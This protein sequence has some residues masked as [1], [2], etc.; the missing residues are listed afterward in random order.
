MTN[1]IDKVFRLLQMHERLSRGESIIKGNAI[2]EFGIPPKT[3]Q[4]DIDSLRLHYTE[5]SQG[6]LVYDRKRNCYRLSAPKTNLT[7]EEIFAICKVLLESR[8]F[9]KAELND[10]I[11]KFLWQC[12]ASERKIVNNLFANERINYI[13]LQHCTPLIEKLW[14]LA[15]RVN[16][17]SII[18]L[19]YKRSDGVVRMYKVK[20]VGVMFSEFYFYLIAYIADDSKVFPTVF[21]ID[22]IIADKTTEQKFNL[23]YKDRFSEAEF[24]KRVQFMYSGELRTVRFLYRGVL[25]AVLDRLPTAKVEKMTDGGAII[26]AEAYGRGIDMWLLSQGDKVEVL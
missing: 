6:E 3:F 22:R 15:E 10:I 14:R 7:K 20:P 19:T 13:P 12:E 9:N 5:Q 26:R 1:K 21:R 23:P 4:R 11:S 25:E 18:E 16:E 17:Q 24:R 2:T 8:A